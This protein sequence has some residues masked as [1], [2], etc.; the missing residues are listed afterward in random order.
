MVYVP[1]MP[2]VDVYGALHSGFEV[3]QAIGGSRD[4]RKAKNALQRIY[5][6]DQSAIADLMAVDPEAGRAVETQIGAQKFI[7]PA[8]PEVELAGPVRPGVD[9]P[10][11]TR[12]PASIDA[13][14]LTTYLASRGDSGAMKALMEKAGPEGK[15]W[16][17]TTIR[18]ADGKIYAIE[19]NTGLVDTGVMGEQEA[20]KAPTTRTFNVGGKSVTQEYDA[21]AG[22]WVTIADAPRELPKPEKPEDPRANLDY[23]IKLGNN[24]QRESE[25]FKTVRQ[26]KDNVDNA[27]AQNSAAGDL[28]AATSIMKLLDPGSVVRESELGM[29]MN[30]TGL[31]GRIGNYAEMIQ[32]GQRLN[33][34]QRKEMLALASQ[35]FDTADKYQGQTKKRYVDMANQYQLNPRNILGAD[36]MP[37]GVQQAGGIPPIPYANA[38]AAYQEYWA[39]YHSA[40]TPEQRKAI[41]ARAR[42]MGVVK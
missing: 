41:T 4:K 8:G 3:G 35:L 28:A 36:Y 16:L 13:E 2:R 33:P 5:A 32:S 7:K 34:E 38:S 10:L 26:A 21:A 11:T 15:K 23:E 19:Q 20:P 14:G 39:A 6:G 29:A 17:G 42:Q 9:E 37:E 25:S 27:L 22:R 31:F 12:T 24:Y 30:A 18:G 1:E 40:K